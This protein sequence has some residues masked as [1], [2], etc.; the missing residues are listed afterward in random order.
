MN[1]LTREKAAQI[2]KENTKQQLRIKKF[3]EFLAQKDKTK[4][5]AEAQSKILEASLN[6]RNKQVFEVMQMLPSTGRFNRLQPDP[7][8]NIKFFD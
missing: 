6:A 3:A 1:D 5:G 7:F 4:L 8:G 2:K